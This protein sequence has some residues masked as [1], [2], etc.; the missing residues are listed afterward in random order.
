MMMQWELFIV[1]GGYL[2]RWGGHHPAITKT[3][4]FEMGS[5]SSVTSC[6][7]AIYE[8]MEK[9]GLL[10]GFYYVD[11]RLKVKDPYRV[12]LLADLGCM[13]LMSRGR[14]VP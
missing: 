12:Q 1:L 3:Q 2:A 7:E 6:L 4:A 5:R 14:N 13:S 10:T 11:L 8:S 9:W